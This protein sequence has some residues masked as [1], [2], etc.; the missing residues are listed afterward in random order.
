MLLSLNWL[1]EYV[2]IPK[3]VSPEDLAQKLTALN[4]EV[5]KIENQSR[6]FDKVVVGEILEVKK[7]PQADRL[8]LAKVNVGQE[9]LDIVCGAPNIAVGQLV[10]VARIGAVLPNGLEIKE[11][12]VRGEKS[13]GMLCAEDELG[14]GADHS[15][16][17]ILDKAKVGQEFSDYLKM[18]D[19]ILEVDNKSLSN[20]PDLWGHYGIARE[21]SAFLNVKLND[22]E[23]GKIKLEPAAEIE[24]QNENQGK[25]KKKTT[26]AAAK[27]TVKMAALPIKIEDAKLCPRY[28]AIKIDGVEIKDSPEWLQEK[29][30]AVGL[31][32]IN[33]IVDITNYVMLALGQPLHAFDADKTKNI[34][35][36]PAKKDE[37]IAALN[38]TEYKLD[39]S[40]LV[41][42]DNQ[43]ALAIAGIIGGTDS[44]VTAATTSII[45]ESANFAAAN[46]RQTST[47]LGVRT[48]ASVRFEK[49]LDPNLPETALQLAVKLISEIDKPA[50]IASA[51]FDANNSNLPIDL[52]EF[53]LDWFDKLA[54]K[55][56]PR[57]QTKEILESLGFETMAETE[58]I[59]NIKIPSWRATKDISLPEDVA[60]E[61]MRIHGYDNF[62]Q[63]LPE[64]LMAPPL[65]NEE[66]RLEWQVKNILAHETKLTEVYNYS[67]VGSEELKKLNLDSTNYL[68]L[69]NPISQTQTLLRQNLAAGLVA[70]V[71]LNQYKYDV[72][73]LFEIGQIYLDVPGEINKDVKSTERLPHQEKRLGI[74]LAANRDDLL[75]YGK[76][77]IANLCASLIDQNLEV[78]FSPTE[79]NLGYADKK[80]P[81]LISINGQDLGTIAAIDP[82]IAKNCGLK[83]PAVLI[84][85]NFKKLAALALGY[86]GQIYQETPKYPPVIR[87]LAFVVDSK[88]LYNDLKAAIKNQHELITKA[89]LFDTYSGANLGPNKK[90]L[91][92]H[93]IYQAPDRTLTAEEIDKI[94]TT[95]INNLQVKFGAQIRNF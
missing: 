79:L 39:P 37:K 41:I 33:N 26:K 29:L 90:S 45:I 67:F 24:D 28:M 3:N 58:N 38:G 35:V 73:G 64:V 82:I 21:I 30:I 86:Q 15:G 87:D 91:A 69:A 32:P 44:G 8:Q 4:V 94:Q 57:K 27:T 85:L 11:A 10:P 70:N 17:L 59:L 55:A 46:I 74:I 9:V 22:L 40:M 72:I 88:V 13:S 54:G 56:M 34:I 5:E 68:K 51:L 78:I 1:K 47:K 75:S 80:S 6:R 95:L 62:S 16:I 20:R 83:K 71:K 81:A 25:S 49:S 31:R 12:V 50:K 63:N 7:H 61:I 65:V 42:A 36:R 66:R 84:E 2:N 93:I 92:F 53:D 77:I 14:L 89:D 48:D 43:K 76:S 52:I 18:N 19:I 60:E 23:L